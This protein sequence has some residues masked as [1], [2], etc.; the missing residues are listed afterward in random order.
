MTTKARGEITLVSIVDVSSVTRYYRLQSS[1]S[2]TPSKPT[3]NPPSGWLS[4]EPAYTSGS[5]N[6]LYFVDLT[7]FSD[8]SYIYSNVSLSTSYEAAKEAYNM[9]KDARDAAN[10]KNKV[11]RQPLA[12]P[13]TSYTEGDIWFDTDDGNL[14]YIWDGSKWEAQP[15][16]SS[17]IG[18][19]DAGKI[20]TGMID[21]DR[22]DAESLFSKEI[23]VEG[24]LKSDDFEEYANG[25]IFAK[26][27][28]A[29]DFGY[30][31]FKTPSFCIDN[32]GNMHVNAGHIGNWVIEDGALH[33][34]AGFRNHNR[35]IVQADMQLVAGLLESGDYSPPGLVIRGVPINSS[36]ISHIVR[37]DIGGGSV[38]GNGATIFDWVKL[39]AI[40]NSTGDYS[41]YDYANYQLVNENFEFPTSREAYIKLQA[42]PPKIHMC[43]RSGISMDGPVS[44]RNYNLHFELPVNKG[45]VPSV[46]NKY[47]SIIFLDNSGENANE[48]RF[49]VIETGLLMDEKNQLSMRVYEPISGS[50]SDAG[51]FLEW[52][53]TND[54]A[55]RLTTSQFEFSG[56][57]TKDI[58]RGTVGD[59][60]NSALHLRNNKHSGSV[61]VDTSGTFGAYDYTYNKWVWYS[62]IY[63]ACL[64]N[65]TANKA[66]TN[67]NGISLGISSGDT[68]TI[69]GM[70]CSGCITG[71]QRIMGFF[72]PLARPIASTSD[73]SCAAMSVIVRHADGGYPYARSGSN[74]ATYTPLGGDYTSIWKYGKTMRTGEISSIALTACT[75]GI[76]VFVT[77]GYQLAKASGNTTAVTNNVPISVHLNATIVLANN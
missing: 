9:A 3:A 69:T 72:I 35:D 36:D 31:T 43:A 28:M 1:T 52:D 46:S 7:E 25:H 61:Q 12:P 53:Q 71:A 63:G 27:G 6:S 68:L 24:L 77:F 22:I 67:A 60:T 57:Y 49:G 34:Y 10:G 20:T 42:Y 13:G 44:I 5:T 16:S 40:D 55:C 26:K 50:S 15:F 39:A 59:T 48:H 75:E 33:G 37:M 30:K 19:L 4:N 8:G 76:S 64:F 51:I 58:I 17:A 62:N 74:G 2:A 45:E 18:N 14:T 38:L 23:T 29:L 56:V 11:Y 65:G 21:A 54:S 73:L 70:L 32:D 41:E 47:R 66:N